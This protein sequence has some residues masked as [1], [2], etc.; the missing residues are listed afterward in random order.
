M[1]PPEA[2]PTVPGAPLAEVLALAPDAKRLDE[3]AV[4]LVTKRVTITL[5]PVGDMVRVESVYGAET[6][7]STKDVK[8]ADLLELIG[9]RFIASGTVN[10]PIN[11]PH[12]RDGVYT[13]QR[14]EWWTVKFAVAHWRKELAAAVAG[15]ATAAPEHRYFE[16]VAYEMR[17]R[18]SLAG[19]KP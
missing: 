5:R 18:I 13:E 19:E 7:N 10:A 1:T 6:F 11:R 4:R 15:D 17:R 2:V 16:R 9:R 8:P 12:E 14:G 3:Q